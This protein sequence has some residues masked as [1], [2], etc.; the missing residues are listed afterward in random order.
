MVI[1]SAFTW[2]EKRFEDIQETLLT[3]KIDVTKE[4]SETK[5]SVIAKI[6]ESNLLL[7]S[8]LDDSEELLIDRMLSTTGEVKKNIQATNA[9]IT[10]L[11][12]HLGTAYGIE[13]VKDE[14]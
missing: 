3:N 1:V 2:A 6:D 14:H 10:D 12:F 9:T 11:M 8:I 5:L 4:I 13:I 7:V